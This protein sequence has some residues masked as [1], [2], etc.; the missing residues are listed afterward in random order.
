M[1]TLR[2]FFIHLVLSACFFASAS[3]ALGQTPKVS[4][5]H[6]DIAY[7][8]AHA[9]QK[10]D[11]YLAESDKPTPAMIYIHGGGWRAGS[12]N[13]VPIWLLKAVREG[14]LSVVSVEYR[15][16]DIATHPADHISRWPDL[17]SC[18]LLVSPS[19]SRVS[20]MRSTITV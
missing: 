19:A 12:K 17:G 16:T 2:Y 3:A 4:A 11:V 9:A 1:N 5:N 6:K 15:F 14:W 10:L 18:H 13:R 7:H 20:G 8:A